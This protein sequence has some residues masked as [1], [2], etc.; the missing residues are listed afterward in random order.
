[1]DM[2]AEA[3]A[4]T[5]AEGQRGARKLRKAV[6]LLI[7]V[8]LLA[9]VVG[10]LYWY[11]HRAAWCFARARHALAAGRFEEV[12]R[13]LRALMTAAAELRVPLRVDVGRGTN[14]DEAH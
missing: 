13:E 10:G 2:T 3:D 6:L 8:A 7:A 1:M 12:E 14:W 11:R 9:A 5:A 4:P